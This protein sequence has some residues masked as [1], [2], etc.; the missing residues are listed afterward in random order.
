MTIANQKI[1]ERSLRKQNYILIFGFILQNKTLA[2][3]LTLLFFQIVTNHMTPLKICFNFSHTK[4]FS[5]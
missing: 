5:M 2:K 3:D 1:L 4:F